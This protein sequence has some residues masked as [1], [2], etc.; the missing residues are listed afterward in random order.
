MDTF[1]IRHGA[2]LDISDSTYRLLIEHETKKIAI[3]YPHDRYTRGTGIDS[4]SLDVSNYEG[5]AAKSLKALN[6]LAKKGGY[7]CATYKFGNTCIVGRVEPGSSIELLRG[8]WRTQAD[9]QAV[10]KSVELSNA[11]VLPPEKMINLLA[12]RPQQGTICRWRAVGDQV[13]RLVE[14]LPV[15]AEASVLSPT[16]QEVMVSETLRSDLGGGLPQ[17]ESLLM[18]V[19]RTLKDVDIFARTVDGKYLL[20]QVT[21]YR[22]GSDNY[23]SK[24][25]RLKKYTKKNIDL[26]VVGSGSKQPFYDQETGV[27]HVGLQYLFERYLATH[28]GARWWEVL[29]TMLGESDGNKRDAEPD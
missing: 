16:L 3:H 7:V 18:P 8:K 19:G 1:F 23:S 6:T 15:K 2:K 12:S 29:K 9:R 10:L 11:Y 24:V 14:K 17:I 26:I 4:E 21:N 13:M 22:N 28:Q 20:V 27:T 5:A 25:K